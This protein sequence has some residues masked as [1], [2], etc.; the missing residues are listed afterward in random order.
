MASAFVLLK[1]ENREVAEVHAEVEALPG[2]TEA[3]VI[4]GVYE[5]FTMVHTDTMPAIEALVHKQIERI[6]GVSSTL[7]LIIL[8][9]EPEEAPEDIPPPEVL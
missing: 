7:T 1:V 3:Y 5:V 8:E 9:P 2:V 4:S 6:K